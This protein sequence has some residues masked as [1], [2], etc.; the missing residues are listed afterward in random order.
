M[1]NSRPGDLPVTAVVRLLGTR[2][3]LVCCSFLPLVARNA[4]ATSRFV[5]PAGSDSTNDCSAPSTPCKTITHALTQ[6]SSSDTISLAAGT[7]NVALGE[8]FPLTIGVD[9][10]VNGASARETIIDATG[11]NARVVEINGASAVTISGV[12]ITGGVASCTGAACAPSVTGTAAAGGGLLN[13]GATLTLT[14][15][16]VSGNAA[17]CTTNSVAVT[18]GA[19]GAGLSSEHGHLMMTNSTLNQNIVSCDVQPLEGFAVCLAQGGGLWSNG[20]DTLTNSTISGNT[21][22]CTVEDPGSVCTL[23]GGGIDSE[24]LAMTLTNVTVTA[25]T[26]NCQA[27]FCSPSWGGAGIFN[28]F[29][30][31]TL[32]SSIVAKQTLGPDCLN[33]IPQGAIV[34]AGFNIDSDG[35]CSLIAT[36]DQPNV[37]NPHLDGLADNGG[38]TQT[39]ALLFGSPAIDGV[40]TGCPPPGTDQRGIRRPQGAHCDIGAFELLVPAA[41]P[42]LGGWSLATLALLIAG[43]GLFASRRSSSG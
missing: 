8:S 12:T 7:Y 3:L 37:T 14:R 27:D 11:A 28:I 1:I 22:T 4:F 41:V 38:P 36:G 25:N 43:A 42:A 34:S 19:R 5:E 40:T 15:S 23:S 20:D 17:R 13:L 32:G 18:C 30:T 26:F 24:G 29:S 35:T 6:A 16:T 21:A 10:T 2:L 39:H 33:S 31:L 9:L